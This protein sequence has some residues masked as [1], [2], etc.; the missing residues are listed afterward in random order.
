[1]S[2]LTFDKAKSLIDRQNFQYRS[3][4]SSNHSQRLSSQ[5]CYFCRKISDKIKKPINLS[6]L[7]VLN[8]PSWVS[9][10]MRFVKWVLCRTRLQSTVMAVGYYLR[11]RYGCKSVY[12]KHGIMWTSDGR[13]LIPSGGLHAS[14]EFQYP[15][16]WTSWIEK[17]IVQATDIS[18]QSEQCTPLTIFE[19]YEEST[20]SVEPVVPKEVP[21]DVK[22]PSHR[23]NAGSLKLC[24][25][26]MAFR[27]K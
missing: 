26:W 8:Q 25:G 22:R 23:V 21:S 16:P 13:I 20:Q 14:L 27:G 4:A 15:P 5:N 3:F 10:I 1:M 7:A 9:S 11:S 24:N 2:R 17:T 6:Q 19:V 18:Q 12:D